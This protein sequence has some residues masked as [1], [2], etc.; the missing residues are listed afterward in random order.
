ML[1]AIFLFCLAW[2]M[3]VFF[4]I[5]LARIGAKPVPTPPKRIAVWIE[6]RQPIKEYIA[7]FSVPLKIEN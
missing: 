2:G 3:L 6:T 1:T 4:F 5:L 7:Q